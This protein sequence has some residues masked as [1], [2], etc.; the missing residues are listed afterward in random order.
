MATVQLVARIPDDL[1]AAVDDLVREG[2]FESR[3]QAVRIGLHA[4]IERRRRVAVGK[5]IVEGYRRIPQ[6]EDDLEWVE[7]AAAAMIA[8]EPW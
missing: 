3:S 8:E 1:A 2:E 6:S 7:A 5:A 4:V